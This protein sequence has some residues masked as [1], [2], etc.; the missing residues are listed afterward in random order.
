M[1]QRN[2]RVGFHQLVKSDAGQLPE[3]FRL[4]QGSPSGHTP[5]VCPDWL[6][7]LLQKNETEPLQAEGIECCQV[8]YLLFRSQTRK[9]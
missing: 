1:Q 9:S 4:F 6:P 8:L 3:G 2:F 5:R 7:G